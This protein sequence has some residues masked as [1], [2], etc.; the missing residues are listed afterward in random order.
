MKPLVLLPVLSFLATAAPA[1]AQT[2]AAP[3]TS[4]PKTQAADPN[5]VIC[6]KQRSMSEW[7]AQRICLTRADWAEL[8]RRQRAGYGPRG[9]GGPDP[10][11]A[12]TTGINAGAQAFLPGAPARY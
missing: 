7:R 4:A 8:E 10:A 1:T 3:Q 6:K 12:N 9:L 11:N 2:P 5:E